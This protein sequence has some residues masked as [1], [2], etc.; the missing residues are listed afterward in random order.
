MRKELSNKTAVITG[1][2]GGLGEQIAYQLAAKNMNLILIARS[3]DKLTCIQEKCKT[4]T[5]GEVVVFS[6]DL[7]DSEKRQQVI[8]AILA[9]YQVDV[10]VNNAGFGL[11]KEAVDFNEEEMQEMFAL[12]TI[13]LMDMTIKLVPQMKKLG[14][15]SIVQIASL[16]GKVATTKSSVYSATKFAVV[17]F[18][19]ALRLELKKDHITVTTV[20]PGPIATNFFRRAEGNDDYLKAVGKVVYTPEQVAKKVVRGLERGKR[21]VNMPHWIS[22][23]SKFYHLFP[24]CGDFLN[25]IFFDLK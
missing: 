8:D 18:S 1:A 10:L 22:I 9:D 25:V 19:N 21:E 20:N 14:G 13:A 12:N 15:G 3:L 2:S 4:M 24:R 23:L 17:G 11:F 7:T 6:C 16:A 5:T